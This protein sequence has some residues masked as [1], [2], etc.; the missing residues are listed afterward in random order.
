MMKWEMLLQPFRVR[1]NSTVQKTNNDK[2]SPFKKDFDTVCNCTGLRRLQD[3]AQVFP[4]E[5]RDFAR[6]R[7]THSIEVMSIAESLGVSAID[8]IKEIENPSQDDET[9]LLDIPVILRAAALL[10]GQPSFWTYWR[11]YNCRV[12]F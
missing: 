4:L 11:K 1:Q 12:V 10:H 7:L 2:R 8:V 9:I 3:K 5:K 6:T